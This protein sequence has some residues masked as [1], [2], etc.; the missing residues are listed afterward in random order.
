MVTAPGSRVPLLF[1]EV[2]NCFEEAAVLVEKLDRYARFFART[3]KVDG[4]DM[5]MWRQRWSGLPDGYLQTVLPPVLLVFNPVGPRNPDGPRNRSPRAPASTGRACPTTPTPR[6]TRA[7][8]SWRPP[9]TG[10]ANAA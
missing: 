10:C 7:S 9:W 8:R 2:D 3:A 4:K 5:A 6:T 1:V